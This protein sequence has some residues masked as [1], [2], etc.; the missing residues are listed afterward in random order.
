MNINPQLILYGIIA[1][2]V[3]ILVGIGFAVLSMI[4]NR[5]LWNERP[6]TIQ[7]FDQ[8]Y[9][10]LSFSGQFYVNQVQ[11]DEK[12]ISFTQILPNGKAMTRVDL[13]YI[14]AES[15]IKSL[16]DSKPSLYGRE[17][18]DVV[19]VLDRSDIEV[20]A[21]VLEP[22]DELEQNEKIVHDL[23]LLEKGRAIRLNRDRVRVIADGSNYIDVNKFEILIYKDGKLKKPF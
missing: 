22:D 2:G 14:A 11:T 6:Y 19:D 10:K 5:S 23:Y 7:A 4:E 1:V 12:Q 15:Y 20:A 17:L 13:P 21:I 18:E 8:D 16:F 3:F 9:T